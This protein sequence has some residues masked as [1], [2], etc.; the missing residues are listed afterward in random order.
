MKLTKLL[1]IP[2]T[3][4]NQKQFSILDSEHILQYIVYE[5]PDD[6]PLSLALKPGIL[7]F[8]LMKI[9][10]AQKSVEKISDENATVFYTDNEY[11][12]ICFVI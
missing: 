2:K 8:G 5:T 12:Y 1:H 11:I 3:I 6:M 10:L 9:D 7:E 4:N